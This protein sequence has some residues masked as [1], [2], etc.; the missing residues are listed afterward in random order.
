MGPE[1]PLDADDVFEL[2]TDGRRRYVLH[3]LRS[4]TDPVS[5]EELAES[6][7][8]WER[9]S[10]DEATPERDD[11]ATALYHVHLPKLDDA[12]IVD[13]EPTAGVVSLCGNVE[14]VEPYLEL[15]DETVD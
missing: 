12:D 3:H 6:I 14:V 1:R 4:T 10:D 8:D 15:V 2:L 9:N 11:V 7:R 5:V 13:F